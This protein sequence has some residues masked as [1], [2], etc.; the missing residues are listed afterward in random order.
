MEEFGQDIEVFE[1]FYTQDHFQPSLFYESCQLLSIYYRAL[2]T[3]PPQFRISVKPFDFDEWKN[4]NISFRWKSLDTISGDDM[5]LPVDKLVA[6][7]LRA[8]YEAS[9]GS[10]WRE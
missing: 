8:E 4:G 2:F 1:H 9:R 10:R 7:K 3:G 6:D 5:T